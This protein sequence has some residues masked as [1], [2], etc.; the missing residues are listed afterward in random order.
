M[1]HKHFLDKAKNIFQPVY[2]VIARKIL[3]SITNKEG[4]ALDIGSGGGD[5]GLEI[6]RQSDFRLELMDVS[7]EMVRAASQAVQEEGLGKRIHVFAGDVHQIP[8]PDHTYDLVVSRGSL[9]FWKSWPQAFL[10]INRVLKLGGK[11]YLGG[12]FGTKEI[13]D[14]ISRQMRSKDPGWHGFQEGLVEDPV[15][16]LEEAL[17]AAQIK[18][19]DI[20]NR[21]EGLWVQFTGQ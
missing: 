14:D 2:P 8:R 13:K 12:G 9:Y 10:E 20:D 19:Y 15:A 17:R 3:A 6:A 11:A 1:K 5:L 4:L 7:L 16:K 18:N 21:Y